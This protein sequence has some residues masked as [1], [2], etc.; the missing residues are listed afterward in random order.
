MSNVVTS[1]NTMKHGKLLLTFCIYISMTTL[2]TLFRPDLVTWRSYKG[3]FRPWLVGIGLKILGSCHHASVVQAHDH[4]PA[5]CAAAAA[6]VY[7]FHS[8]LNSSYTLQDFLSE[9]WLCIWA[10]DILGSSHNAS[11]VR[12]HDH[13]PAMCAAAAQVYF[14]RSCL[15]LSLLGE[16]LS[17]VG[18]LRSCTKTTS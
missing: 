12:A 10:V 6:K 7:F 14:F 13:I 3:W 15:R 17:S 5:M 9:F 8:C 1:T 16:C 11:V 18:S 2:L 4:L